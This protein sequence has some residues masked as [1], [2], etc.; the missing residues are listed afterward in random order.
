MPVFIRRKLTRSTKVFLRKEYTWSV[1]IGTVYHLQKRKPSRP[2]QPWSGMPWMWPSWS[3]RG[4]PRSLQTTGFICKYKPAWSQTIVSFSL[5]FT[6]LG[7]KINGKSSGK[8]Q[9]SIIIWPFFFLF[10]YFF[11]PIEFYEGKIFKIMNYLQRV[12][13][14]LGEMIVQYAHQ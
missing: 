11:L 3:R 14:I 12:M 7:Y 9:L 10:D 5:F 6:C 13:S 8:Q 1:S 4:S 2:L